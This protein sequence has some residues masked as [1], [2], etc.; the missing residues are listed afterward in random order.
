MNSGR[1]AP[2][3][4]MDLVLIGHKLSKNQT[5]LRIKVDSA[6]RLVDSTIA[7]LRRIAFELRPRTWMIS[8]LHCCSRIAG[9]RVP[10]ADRN[11]VQ[12]IPAAG[13]ASS[14]HRPVHGLFRIFQESLTNVAR[15]A[16]ATRVE[17][18]LKHERGRLIFQVSDN[19]LGLIRGG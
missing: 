17:A 7:S 6:I 16:H 18:R 2:A 13:T 9:R 19:A 1:L 8:G 11:S 10:D 4:K 14:R 15:H 12:R 3:I 5:H